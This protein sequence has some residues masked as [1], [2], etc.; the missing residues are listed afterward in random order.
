MIQIAALLCLFFTGGGDWSID[1][2]PY[3]ATIAGYSLVDS[4]ARIELGF[5]ETGYPRSGSWTSP[6]SNATFPITGAVQ[7][8]SQSYISHGANG[9]GGGISANRAFDF[10]GTLGGS[11]N[12]V[13]L[14]A[15]T[16][17]P[18]R[19]SVRSLHRMLFVALL[20]RFGAG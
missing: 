18:Q 2:V 5:K 10:T 14:N 8:V 3:R 11:G 7:V 16:I 17:V 9:G 13:I 15:G 4:P 1:G 12:M 19:V 20:T 6:E